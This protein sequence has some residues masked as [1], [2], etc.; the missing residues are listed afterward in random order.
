MRYHLHN[1]WQPAVICAVCALGIGGAIGF[2]PL[3]AQQQT[4]AV[5]S[6]NPLSGDPDSIKAGR[7]LFNTFAR[8]VTA[9]TRRASRRS[10]SSAQT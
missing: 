3:A 5:A 7:K 2:G 6:D 10:A 9:A 4:A 1:A 8:N